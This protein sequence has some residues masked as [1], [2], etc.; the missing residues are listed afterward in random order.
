MFRKRLVFSFAVVLGALLASM[1][2]G[3]AQAVYGQIFGTVRDASGGSVPGAEVTITDVGKGTVFTVLTNEDGNYTKTRLIPGKYQVKIALSGFKTFVQDD[4]IVTA[5]VAARVDAR[6]EVGQISEQVV[7]TGEAP[8]LKS[9]RA[10]VSTVLEEKAVTELPLLNRNF[11]ELQLLLPGTSKQTW[12]HASSENPQGST[13]IMVNGQPFFGTGFLLDGTDN[14]D[15]ILGIIVINPVLD[16]VQEF[17]MTTVNF[18]AEFGNAQSAIVTAQTKSGGNDLHGSAYEFH[19]NS[20]TNARNPFSESPARLGGKRIPPA[21][22]NQFGATTG[23]PIIKNKAFFFGYYEGT[24]QRNGSSVLT[25]VPTAAAHDGDLSAYG[26]NIYDPRTGAADGSGRS[27]F[28][29]NRIPTSRLSTQAQNLLKLIP[30]PNTSTAG[31]VE[32]NF[33]GGGTE[34]LDSDQVGGRG[35][36]YLSPQ[37]HI[38][39]RYSLANFNKAAPGAFGELVGGPGLNFIF[40]GGT[41]HVRNQSLATGFDYTLNPSLLTDFRFGY[42]RYLVRVRP[43]AAGKTPAKDAGIPGLNVDEFTAD[44]PAFTITGVGAF[45]FGYSLGVNQCNCPLDQTEN[46]LQFVNNWTK[47]IR[48]HTVKAG[49]DFRHAR[50]LRVPS[51]QHRSGQLTFDSGYTSLLGAANTGLGVASFLLGEVTFFNR[52]VS[53]TRDAGERQ[54]RVYL[55]AQDTWRVTPRLTLN[56]GLRWEYYQPENVTGPGKGANVDISTG[57]VLVYGVGPVPLNGGIEASLDNFAPRIGIAYQLNEKTVIR[58]GYG[59]SYDIG[60]FGAAF[61]HTV[62]QNLPVLA[63]QELVQPN[64]FTSV[65]NLGVGPVAPAFPKPDSN[66]RFKLPNGIGMFYIEPRLKMPFA[67]NWNVS[68]QRQITPTLAGEVAYVGN[69]GVHRVAYID[70]NVPRV[71]EGTQNSRRQFFPKF[72]WTQSI[73]SRQCNC[74]SSNYHSLQMKLEKRFAKDYWFLTHY[75]WAKGFDTGHNGTGNVWNRRLEYAPTDFDRSQVFVVNSIYELPIGPGKKYLTNG[76]AAKILGGWSFNNVITLESGLPFSPGLSSSAPLDTGGTAYRPNKLGDPSLNNQSRDK[77]FNA[78]PSTVGTVWGLPAARTLGN[79]ARNSLRGPGVATVDMSFFKNFN[80]WEE[81][82]LQ[83]RTELFNIFNRTNLSN[84]NGTVDSPTAGVISG[85]FLPM[86]R[87]QW[88]LR[89]TF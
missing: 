3:H 70:F 74:T 52:Y 23:G 44:M 32:N 21:R 6:L 35:D 58:M 31:A 60:T 66:G 18:D 20:A 59:R 84:P 47:I 38:F 83:F 87:I 48:N 69:Q 8:L 12:Q 26:R 42:Y 19:R 51:D 10:D 34:K 88:A 39:G 53:E 57:D 37:F 7:V 15:P 41:S 25:T 17:K 28:T 68:V 16:S 2:A 50:N 5:D 79:A 80:L 1:P 73:Q 89:V 82:K 61:G 54:N 75:T 29:G 65:F 9:D 63:R 85:I 67:E 22:W 13:Q 64:P 24:R 56:L 71:G 33:A 86:R 14:R 30:L 4:V 27:Q 43:G 36:V 49:I 76:V 55:Y 77:W 62:T 46:Q 45:R 11:S 78:G 40:F 81:A 72:G